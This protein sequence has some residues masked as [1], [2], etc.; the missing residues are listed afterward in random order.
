MALTTVQKRQYYNYHNLNKKSLENAISLIKENIRGVYKQE[1]NG[2]Y[3]IRTT[4][5]NPERVKLIN[6]VRSYNRILLGL[7]AS[8]S[9]ESIRRLYYEENVFTEDQIN[10]LLSRSTALEQKWKLA[11][12]IAFCKAQG[13]IPIGNETCQGININASAFPSIDIGLINKYRAVENLIA[14]ILVPAFNIR[15]KVQHGEW[16]YA[17]SPPDSKIFS[18][19]ITVKISKENIV[20][21][22]AR[23][24][25]FNSVYQMIIDLSRF[26]SG[27]FKIDPTTT[28]FEYF[29]NLHLKK[30]NFEI[31]KISSPDI[32]KYIA[33]LIRRNEMG[34]NYRENQQLIIPEKHSF[35]Q[36]IIFFFIGRK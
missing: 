35:F 25:V 34:K 26:N 6:D 14:N 13:L 5:T 31:Q 23:M 19:E 3:T 33:E 12:K 32:N 22:S 4:F 15:N 8:W 9:D 20:S 17:F 10:Y 1:I 30:I 18:R 11:L 27:N 16:I 2:N 36:K 7:L 29:H 21:I 28:P 24:T